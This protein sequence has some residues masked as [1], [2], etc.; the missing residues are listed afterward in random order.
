[1][2][3]VI[4]LNGCGS[5]GKSSVAKAIAHLSDELWL[6]FGIDTFINFIP[7]GRQAEYLEFIPG[8]NERGPTMSVQRARFAPALF[9]AMPILAQILLA[10][11]NNL[12]IDEVLFDA[13]SL[14]SYAQNLANYKVYYIGIYC[15]LAIMQEREILR[16]DRCIGLSNDQIDRVHRGKLGCYDLKVDTSYISPFDAARQI[17]DFIDQNSDPKAF[18]QINHIL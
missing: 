10:K 3:K 1:M 12:I 2:S 7:M 18:K 8:K 17:L 11:G 13:G 9:A 15:D 16:G 4:F 6:T 14:Q 5:S